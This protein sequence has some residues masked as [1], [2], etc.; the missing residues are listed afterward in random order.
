MAYDHQ[1]EDVGE[2]RRADPGYFVLGRTLTVQGRT[3]WAD[4]QWEALA[5]EMQ[6]FIEERMEALAVDLEKEF[7]HRSPTADLIIRWS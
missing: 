1:A 5:D 3:S 2:L 6:D 7:K 4:S